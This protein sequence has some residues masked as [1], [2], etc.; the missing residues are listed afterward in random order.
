VR[1]PDDLTYRAGV[2]V[3]TEAYYRQTDIL[4]RD[5]MRPSLLEG[6]GW[7]IKRVLAKDW[8]RNRSAVLNSLIQFI[9]QETLGEVSE[10][11]HSEDQAPPSE[12]AETES[13]NDDEPAG[14]VA[15]KDRI[16]ETDTISEMA[17]VSFAARTD[18]PSPSRGSQW[19]R[20]FEF[21]GGTSHKFWEITMNDQEHT[22][23]FGRIGS[24]GQ[25]KTKSFAS[26]ME[27]EKDARRL[28]NEKLGKGY[29]ESK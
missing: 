14:A 8:Y 10:E 4:E 15:P 29:V 21:T 12:T 11:V 24:V 2:L 1:R 20:Y 9:E 3:D 5:V 28:I 16:A 25:Q 6:F 13:P 23:R 19:K 27:A 7:R 18:S 26:A 22:V 17:K